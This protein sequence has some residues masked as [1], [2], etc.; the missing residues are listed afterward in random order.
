LLGAFLSWPLYSILGL[1]GGM[2]ILVALVISDLVI[3]TGASVANMGDAVSGR[4]DRMRDSIGTRREEREARRT[5]R[6]EEHT[7]EQLQK[8]QVNTRPP[9]MPD[10]LENEAEITD[11]QW[12]DGTRTTSRIIPDTRKAKRDAKKKNAAAEALSAWPDRMQQVPSDM[13]TDS[14][15]EPKTNRGAPRSRGRINRLYVETITPT[16]VFPTDDDTQNHPWDEAPVQDGNNGPEP[17]IPGRPRPASDAGRYGS[18]ILEFT[19]DRADRPAARPAAKRGGSSLYIETITPTNNVVVGPGAGEVAAPLHFRT[20]PPAETKIEYAP[21]PPPENGFP[22]DE[23]PW[24]EPEKRTEV[25]TE[26]RLDRT[27]IAKPA[28]RQN[29]MPAQPVPYR[30]PPYH[31]LNTPKKTI[32]EDTRK[33]DELNAAKLL[34]T[35]LSFG[36]QARVLNVTHGPAI[37]RYELQPAPGI[38]V[39]RIVSLVDDIALNMAAAGVRIEAPIPGK[40]AVGIEIPNES[41]ATVMLREVLESDELQSHASALACALGKDI[42]GRR[43]VA[44]L[45]RMPHMLIAGAT[46]SGKSVCINTLISSLIFRSSPEEV[47]MILVDPKVVELSVYNGIP[48][49]L[50]PVVTDP[51]KASG[52]LGWTVSEM[53]RRYKEFASHAARDIRSFNAML[54]EEEPP[55]PQIVVIID[56]LADLMMVAPGEVEESICRLAQLARA[57][58]IHL[59]IATQRPSVNVI[60]GVIKA[61]IPSRIAF[62]VSSQVDS[63][64]ILDSA[65]AEKLLGKGDMLYA[66]QGSGKPIRVQGCFVTDDEVARVVEYVKNNHR[67]AENDEDLIEYMNSPEENAPDS[68]NDAEST[69]D[70]LL[71]QAIEIALETGQASISMLQ[72]RLRVGYARAGRLIDEMARRGIIS[73][74]EGAK[75]REALMS[76][77]EYRRLFDIEK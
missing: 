20:D 41:I 53:E 74:A 12:L 1:A 23:E 19:D 14:Y 24:S 58:G 54:R 7:I 44:D 35:L 2:V 46:G 6:E 8:R 18:T 49:L 34:E 52:A 73:Q 15:T 9:I 30:Y 40:A 72:R 61:N 55:M 50:A 22:W 28:K 17:W 37:T 42:A 48:H 32:K 75:P 25:Q 5:A 47:R 76:R 67:G 45:A 10:T 71:P 27:P 66:P 69:A 43:V 31:L 16:G 70:E 21:P 57:A 3:L 38:K 13:P 26:R 33:Q 51:K 36:I 60:T 63:R 11:Q 4:W 39:S 59:V 68:H 77:E 56:E 64:T 62:A 29:E 65:G